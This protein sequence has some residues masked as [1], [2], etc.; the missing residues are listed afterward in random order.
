MGG[1]ALTPRD[2]LL[3]GCGFLVEVGA[4]SWCGWPGCC[5]KTFSVREWVE[6]E[7]AVAVGAVDAVDAV[8]FFGCEAAAVLVGRSRLGCREAGRDVRQC[9]GLVGLVAG[10]EG[11][12]VWSGSISSLIVRMVEGVVCGVPSWAGIGSGGM[13]G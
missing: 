13:R 8:A 1:A 2:S 9:V 3:V 7:W 4:A 10:F 5:A 12:R 11:G 6:V